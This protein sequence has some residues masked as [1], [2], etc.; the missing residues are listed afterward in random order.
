[1]GR[2]GDGRQLRGGWGVGH[3]E[4]SRDSQ[5]LPTR[6]QRAAPTRVQRR[7]TICCVFHRRVSMHLR[8][9]AL[10]T[11][12]RPAARHSESDAHDQ[13]QRRAHEPS[14]V[15]S[16]HPHWRTL[17]DERIREP[18][19]RPVTTQHFLGE[20]ELDAPQPKPTVRVGARGSTRARRERG[21]T[22]SAGARGVTSKN[23]K[24]HA[25]LERRMRT[26]GTLAIGSM[27]FVEQCLASSTLSFVLSI[28]P[29]AMS[30]SYPSS[31]LGALF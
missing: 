21:R 26:G 23:E 30:G 31:G 22:E 29:Y 14:G 3:G 17:W 24:R 2:G 11:R 15:A 4:Q 19:R 25:E 9:R 7:P 12:S 18:K 13:R 28:Y 5:F 20:E 6:D 8:L 10:F 16:T 27:C 1:M